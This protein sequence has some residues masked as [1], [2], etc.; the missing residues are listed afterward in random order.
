MLRP[1]PIGVFDQ[2]TETENTENGMRIA[3][4]ELSLV[5][6]ERFCHVLFDMMMGRMC[7]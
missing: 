4:E 1:L 2:E 5:N 7:S 3:F 6:D